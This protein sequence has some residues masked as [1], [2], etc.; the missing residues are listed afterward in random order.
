[1]LP[2]GVIDVRNH[3]DPNEIKEQYEEY[4]NF[5]KNSYFASSLDDHDKQYMENF[6]VKD[7]MASTLARWHQ[8][9]SEVK[10][11]SN[12]HDASKKRDDSKKN[13]KNKKDVENAL[14]I[15]NFQLLL[16]D[17]DKR[18]SSSSSSYTQRYPA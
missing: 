16:E 1:M 13:K 7:K 5:D 8:P 14:P 3:K 10:D 12:G 17:Q 18:P 15:K 2:N 11:N 6:S 9:S 4:E